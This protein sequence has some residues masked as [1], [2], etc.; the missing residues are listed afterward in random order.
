LPGTEKWNARY[1]KVK[2]QV[3]IN[4]LPGKQK[5]K[6]TGIKR[7]MPGNGYKKT[8]EK[9]DRE[10]SDPTKLGQTFVKNFLPRNFGSD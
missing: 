8:F 7:K 9:S 6:M 1:E 4:E 3:E 2:S 5:S 10:I